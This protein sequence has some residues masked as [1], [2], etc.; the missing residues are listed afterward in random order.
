VKTRR[1]ELTI[2]EQFVHLTNVDE[3][4]SSFGCL[5]PAMVS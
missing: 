3:I 2:T 4:L 5:L 1:T